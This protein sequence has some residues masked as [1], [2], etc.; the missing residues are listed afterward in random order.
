VKEGASMS[1]SGVHFVHISD[2]H[3]GPSVDDSLHG[4]QTYE[5]AVAVIDAINAIDAPVDF[6]I[7]TGDVTTD[8][9][10]PGVDS[11][12]TLLAHDLLG[13]I[14]FPLHIL[15]GNHDSLL[16]LFDVFGPPKGTPLA[17]AAY[18]RS[19]HFSLSDERFVILDARGEP[20]I[21]PQ[22]M[23]SE[24]QL[25]AFDRVVMSTTEP[26]TLFIH[27]P[28][29]NLDSEWLNN[30]MLIVNGGKLHERLVN[31]AGRLRGV[32]FGHVHRGIQVLFDGILYCSVGSTACH[33]STWPDS[34]VLTPEV[35]GV[36]FFNYVSLSEQG[37]I[38][39]Q[40]WVAIP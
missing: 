12:S 33:F 14:R 39:K 4:S 21:D 6:V 40:H 24:E 13:R 31:A 18:T 8:G 10:T 25:I 23:L 27:Y 28:P 1:A 22:G 9:D 3:I 37:T 38:V 16:H 19:C 34:T 26:L 35:D 20:R 17:N 32:F 7:H 29:I 30:T 15:N 2:T 5:R 36:L 11:K